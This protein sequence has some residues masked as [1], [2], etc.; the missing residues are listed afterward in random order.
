MYFESIPHCI[1]VCLIRTQPFDR[2]CKK[3]AFSDIDVDEI[4]VLLEEPGADLDQE[5][6]RCD[7]VVQRCSKLSE[8]WH[9]SVS[10][11][12]I[13]LEKYIRLTHLGRFWSSIKSVN[14]PDQNWYNLCEGGAKQ[15]DAVR[16]CQKFLTIYPM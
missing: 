15:R 4:E 6:L 5:P 3:M 8:V 12:S 16:L 1:P 2:R 13:P 7:E 9:K 14:D 10:P 11:A